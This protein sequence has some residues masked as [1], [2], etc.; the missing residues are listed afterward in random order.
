MFEEARPEEILFVSEKDPA[1]EAAGEISEA[2]A[3]L[4][5]RGFRV[6][7]LQAESG[8]ELRQALSGLAPCRRLLLA[9]S[10]AFLGILKK[11]GLAAAA[12]SHGGNREE[13]FPG[14]DYILQEPGWIDEDS[15]NKIYQRLIGKPWKILETERTLV[16]EFVPEDLEAIYSLY[17]EE[18]L[19]FLEPPGPDRDREKKILEAYIQKI[20]GL[21]GF[22][23]WAVL[24]KET[25]E[26]IGRMGFEAPTGQMAERLGADAMFGYLTAASARR[27]GLTGEVLPALLAYGDAMLGFGLVG[28]EADR[29]NTVSIRLLEKTGF[30]PKCREGDKIFFVRKNPLQRNEAGI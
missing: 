15:W 2:K 27:K 18:A 23:H 3:L 13:T 9:D 14:A 17:D 16:R 5:G 19:R 26:L 1:P 10:A 20:Y 12:W 28:A 8:E 6:S 21:F 7:C 29:D 24:E 30:A 4:P 22:G 11:E 25:G